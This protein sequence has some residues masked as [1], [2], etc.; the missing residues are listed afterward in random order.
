MGKVVDMFYF[1]LFSFD[2]PSW[3]PFCGGERFEFFNAIFNIADSAITVGIVMLLI[4][5]MAAE[6]R[7][8][9]KRGN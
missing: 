7:A 5:Y 3:V 9:K 1:A 6:R 8:R 4:F 2:W